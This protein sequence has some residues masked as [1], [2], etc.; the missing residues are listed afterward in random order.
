MKGVAG[1]FLGATLSGCAVNNIGETEGQDY[2]PESEQKEVESDGELGDP[3]TITWYYYYGRML[4]EEEQT[5]K[6][7]EKELSKKLREKGLPVELAFKLYDEFEFFENKDP[8]FFN[9]ADILSLPGNFPGYDTYAELARKGMLACWDEFLQTSEGVDLRTCFPEK[10]WKGTEVDGK[11]Y[12]LLTPVSALKTYYSINK[13]MADKYEIKEEDIND[14]SIFDLAS[15]VYQKETEAGNSKLMGLEAY[16]FKGLGPL[17]YYPLTSSEEIGV[18]Q[19]NGK[20]KAS[21]LVDIPE[22]QTFIRKINRLYLE[23][24]YQATNEQRAAGN[25]FAMY[26]TSYSKN[27][28]AK[29]SLSMISSGLRNEWDESDF[30]IRE[31]SIT[32]NRRYRGVGA[33]TAVWEASSHKSLS[34]K[35]LAAI[36]GDAELSEMISYGIMGKDCKEADDGKRIECLKGDYSRYFGNLFL[37]RSSTKEDENRAEDVWNLIEQDASPI[38]G[39]H[40]DTNGSEEIWEKILSIQ[41]AYMDTYYAGLCDSIEEEEKKIREQLKAVG[42]YAVLEEIENQLYQFSRE[43]GM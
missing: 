17:M 16:Q 23:G 27:G 25:F 36:Y 4:R 3:V 28:A 38:C 15:Y 8:S 32:Q 40:L 24:V 6:S 18:Y 43:T 34:M 20:W 21:F 30:L 5:N 12:T 35:V 1:C 22:Y 7:L 37:M 26:C 10:Y 33:R 14:E 2:V 31:A 19:E 9:G 29:K 13:R 42:G 41:T 11:I 39:F